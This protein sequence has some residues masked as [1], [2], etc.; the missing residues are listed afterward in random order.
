MGPP[1]WCSSMSVIRVLDL[2]RAVPM[3]YSA[4]P[5]A[6]TAAVPAPAWTNL[7]DDR[8]RTS[9]PHVIRSRVNRF[10][11]PILGAQALKPSKARHDG[12]QGM[13]PGRVCILL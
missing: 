6:W 5:L 1:F 3:L 4:V 9:L 7:G 11:F 13:G 10:F 12:D 8:P 2:C